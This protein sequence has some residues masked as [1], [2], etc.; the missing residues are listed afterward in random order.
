LDFIDEDIKLFTDTV[1]TVSNA[2]NSVKYDI[3]SV[4]DDVFPA[5]F[6][7]FLSPDDDSEC[8]ALPFGVVVVVVVSRDLFFG[9]FFFRISAVGCSSSFELVSSVSNLEKFLLKKKY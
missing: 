2:D 7:M 8:A 1:E 9:G 3:A 5:F 4:D 6:F